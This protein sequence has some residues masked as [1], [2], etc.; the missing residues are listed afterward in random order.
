MRVYEPRLCGIDLGFH[1]YKALYRAQCAT[2]AAI[3]NVKR[4]GGGEFVLK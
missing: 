4:D 2:A 3:D 1:V